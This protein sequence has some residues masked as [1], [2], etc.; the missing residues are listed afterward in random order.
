M[1]KQTLFDM[2]YQVLQKRPFCTCSQK[3]KRIY[4]AYCLRVAE[5]VTDKYRD[6][7]DKYFKDL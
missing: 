5:T 7:I 4:G 2:I 6:K 3:N 1:K